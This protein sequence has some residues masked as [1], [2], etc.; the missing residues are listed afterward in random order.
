MWFPRHAKWATEYAL[1]ETPP[2]ENAIRQYPTVCFWGQYEVCVRMRSPAHRSPEMC[3]SLP[4][5]GLRRPQPAEFAEVWRVG[6][7]GGAGMI[8]GFGGW[9]SFAG[10]S[11]QQ[12]KRAVGSKVG[13]P[14]LIDGAAFDDRTFLHNTESDAVHQ[15]TKVTH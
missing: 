9:L 6:M 10:I 7:S 3:E 4:V 8:R 5:L 13:P 2:I 14:K 12:V 1:R 15:V 11:L